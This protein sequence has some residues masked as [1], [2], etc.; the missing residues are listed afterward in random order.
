[1]SIAEKITRAKADFDEVYNA[2]YNKGQAEGGDTQGAY[3]QGVAD[4]IEQGKQSEY[5]AFWD[6]YQDYGNR[7]EY[8]IY[9]GAFGGSVWTDALFKPKYPFKPTNAQMM[10]RATG[11][12]DLTRDDIALDFSNC[13]NMNTTFAYLT[14]SIKLPLIDMS[15]ATNCVSCF[16][17]YKDAAL[18]LISSE[19]TVFAN[20][21]F[22]SNSRLTNLTIY[23]VIGKNGFN[24]QWSTK[25]THESLMS[26]INALQDKSGDTTG[27]TWTLTLGSENIAKLTADEQKIAEQ[28]GWNLV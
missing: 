2:G 4:G 10:F 24:V 9:K 1:M 25:L 26:I 16:S 5:D 19:K 22:S 15:S 12:T 20:N 3:D 8:S 14:H 28:K 13:D 27:T 6:N 11:I 18:S 7:T 23:G 17:D 21:S